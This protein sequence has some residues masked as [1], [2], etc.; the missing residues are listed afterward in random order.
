MSTFKTLATLVE[1]IKDAL[2]QSIEEAFELMDELIVTDNKR[3]KRDILMQKARYNT[4]RNQLNNNL[5][6]IAE[7]NQTYGKIRFALFD[8]L[9]SLKETDIQLG[10]KKDSGLSNNEKAGLER[11]RELLTEKM[12]FFKEELLITS[13]PDVKFSLKKKLQDIEV[14]LAKIKQQLGE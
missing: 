8:L 14:E 12:N 1:A 9:D 13:S 7:A 5:I 6:S 2:T 3:V 4:T 11:Q 10:Q